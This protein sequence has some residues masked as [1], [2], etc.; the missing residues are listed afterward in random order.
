MPEVASF[1]TLTRDAL[2]LTW[3]RRSLW[4]IAAPVALCIG[5]SSFASSLFQEILPDSPEASHWPLVLTNEQLPVAALLLMAAIFG[6]SFLRGAIVFSLERWIREKGLREIKPTRLK[7]YFRAALVS[8]FF[9]V[10]Y[11]LLFVLIATTLTIPCLVAWHFNPSVFPII[12]QIG[13]LLLMTIGVYLYFVK[14]LSAFYAVL[15]GI[16]PSLAIDLGFRLFRRHVFDT[17][18]F[19]FYATLLALFF[20]LI[21][22]VPRALFETS[23]KAASWETTLFSALPLG[24]YFIFDQALRLTFFRSIAAHPKKTMAEERL[25]KPSESP[26]GIAP[27]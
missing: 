12:V 3:Q 26:S 13:F 19:F 16:R 7:K 17:A 20:T 14:E 24:L 21:I 1:T 15:G 18:L 6:Q 23:E 4:W 5:I 2:Q 22:G 11:W 9:E 8:A 10:A 27:N 25:L